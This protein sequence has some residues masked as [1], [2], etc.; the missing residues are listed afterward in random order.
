MCGK[1]IQMLA[2]FLLG[3]LLAQL[4]KA[5]VVPTQEYP[6]SLRRRAIVIIQTASSQKMLDS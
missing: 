2:W 1:P 5:V 3:K 6:L 4:Q